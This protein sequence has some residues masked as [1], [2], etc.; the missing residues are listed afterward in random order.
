MLKILQRADGEV[1]GCQ[2][3]TPATPTCSRRMPHP[4]AHLR[5]TRLPFL[6][7][8]HLE[9]QA[10]SPLSL[11]SEP[12]GQGCPKVSAGMGE[13]G[14]GMVPDAHQW[15]PVEPPPGLLL[16]QWL[17][18]PGSGVGTEVGAA[19]Q[20]LKDP[21]M[22]PVTPIPLLGTDRRQGKGTRTWLLPA[23]PHMAP[24]GR[25]GSEGTPCPS[26]SGT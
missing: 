21:T 15:P 14:L 3:H 16:N 18:T 19:E 1:E 25:G 8:C 11:P 24:A 10:R 7:S 6:H 26:N 5:F 13:L 2:A 4:R 12:V 17:K 22:L 9:T 20:P 23:A